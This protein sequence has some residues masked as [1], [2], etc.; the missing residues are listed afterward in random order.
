VKQRL[1]SRLKAATEQ[2]GTA[3]RASLGVAFG[4]AVTIGGTVGVGIL[5]I[6][7]PVAALTS[8]PWLALAVWVLG[9]CYALLGANYIAELAAM[10]P[11]AGGPYV[12]ARRAYGGFGGFVVG[13][14]DW[15][16]NTAALAFVAISFGEFAG[17]LLI[18]L[19]ARPT[20]I[21]VLI[22][23]LLAVINAMGI[24]TGS[25]TQ[26]AAVVVKMAT[27]L[28]FIVACLI[29][30]SP[31]R[32]W[33]SVDSERT[34]A[35]SGEL[36]M[37]LAAAFQLVL[38][39]YSGWNAAS[40]F[41]EEDR[42][43]ARNLPRS[44]FGG[45]AAV[46]GVF[47]LT[48][49]GLFIMLPADVVAASSF[50]GA[51]AVERMVGAR[52]RM[53]VAVLSLLLLLSILNT[54]FLTMPRTLLAASRDGLLSPSVTFVNHGGTPVVALFVTVAAA[55]F[56]TL[57][58]TFEQLLALYAIV[59]VLMNMS[60]IGALLRLRW[61]EPELTRPF[62]TI[63]YPMTPCAMLAVDV[64]LFAVFAATHTRETVTVLLLLSA[65]YPLYR[66]IAPARRF[67]A[68]L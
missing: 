66:A 10:L 67:Q 34:M 11:I 49:L 24:R 6:P 64:A 8:T 60:L 28:A 41:S 57:T 13:L 7:G 4:I 52:A 47:V 61:R 18:T 31:Q 15:L 42:A 48:N 22:L 40:Y 37:S 54:T 2:R 19:S 55:V 17:E 43:P 35:P 56:M 45:V 25:E 68:T 5:R 51:D 63:G 39:A 65:S 12:F 26:K 16:M 59:G 38:V 27:L 23:I 32:L 30:G 1:D 44:L 53:A 50:P 3:L 46:V 9:G 58:G 33:S 20:V 62:R 14:A 21:A 36:L 29:L